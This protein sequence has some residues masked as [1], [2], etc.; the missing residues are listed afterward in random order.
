[1]AVPTMQYTE[2]AVLLQVQSLHSNPALATKASAWLSE[3]QNSS[4]A[5]P[6]ATALLQKAKEERNQ[7]LLV[8]NFAAHTIQA[9][10]QA[11]F[12]AATGNLEVVKQ[13][14][15]EFLCDFRLSHDLV[16]RPLAVALCAVVLFD[17]AWTD[18]VNS[19]IQTFATH[20]DYYRILAEVLS[21][22]PEELSNTNIAIKPQR[23]KEATHAV[24]SQTAVAFDALERLAT[25]STHKDIGVLRKKVVRATAAWIRAHKIAFEEDPP[26]TVTNGWVH[27]MVVHCA[28]TPVMEL[29]LQGLSSDDI[30]V[31]T[32]AA[33]GIETL[34]LL[35]V[36]EGGKPQSALCARIVTALSP[37]CHLILSD[38]SMNQEDDVYT[39]AMNV[40]GALAR[41]Q[42]PYLMHRV[43][44]AA[45]GASGGTDDAVYPAVLPPTGGLNGV[46]GIDHTQAAPQGA[47]DD[48]GL[49]NSDLQ[50]LQSPL[51]ALVDASLM[52]CSHP[53]LQVAEM[54]LDFWLNLATMFFP[55]AE[56]EY[57]RHQGD[58]RAALRLAAIDLWRRERKES[59]R[60]VFMTFLL[61]L[62]EIVSYKEDGACTED[63]EAFEAF[64]ALRNRITQN[65]AEITLIF[66]SKFA[67]DHTGSTLLGLI[68][69]VEREGVDA[70]HYSVPWN[71]LEANVYLLTTIATRAPRGED[72][73]I[74]VVLQRIPQIPEA[75]RSVQG[76]LL[77]SSVCRFITFTCTYAALQPEL[78]TGL[79]SYVAS[80]YMNFFLTEPL[81]EA[82][83]NH[84]QDTATDALSYLA[85]A[86]CGAVVGLG[87]D[88]V[89]RVLQDFNRLI[90]EPRISIDNRLMLVKAAGTV[91]S[92]LPTGELQS[93]HGQLVKP[94]ADN[95]Q[96][97]LQQ[98]GSDGMQT[99]AL[100]LFFCGLSA[101]RWTPSQQEHDERQEALAMQSASGLCHP[102]LSLVDAHLPLIRGAMEAKAKDEMCVESATSSMNTIL[103]QYR[104]ETVPQA[105]V[106][107]GFLEA[108]GAC[109]RI[110][111]N[112]FLLG[113]VRT[114]VGLYGNTPEESVTGKGG[115]LTSLL[116]EVFESMRL[117]IVESRGG[118]MFCQPDMVGMSVDCINCAVAHAALACGLF[119]SEQYPRA[120]ATV[121]RLLVTCNHPKVQ[122]ALLLFLQRSFVWVDP[123]RNLH[124]VSRYGQ[125]GRGPPP[126]YGGYPPPAQAPPPPNPHWV[127]TVVKAGTCLHQILSRPLPHPG[128]LD[129]A[130]GDPAGSGPAASAAMIANGATGGDPNSTAL[131]ECLRVLVS[132]LVIYGADL[133]SSLPMISQALYC[134]M[135]S[136][137]VELRTPEEIQRYGGGDQ[138]L[139]SALQ[140]LLTSLVMLFKASR[141]ALYD[142]LKGVGEEFLKPDEK[143]ELFAKMVLE[144]PDNDERKFSENLK[145]AAVNA[146]MG[147]KQARFRMS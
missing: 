54:G 87:A 8:T 82:L 139:Q 5:W 140:D 142:A 27:D 123:G 105:T 132:V 51:Q 43:K 94:L 76:A 24:L 141:Q 116:W 9:Q 25:A 125:G 35:M 130:G 96:R 100:R 137:N 109:A 45:S 135:H 143:E 112:V 110:H 121:T 53:S 102:V 80:H 58:Q 49:T 72:A 21:I 91:V 74:P 136:P 75:Y 70:A 88:A 106:L 30:E 22:L 118:Y 79:F 86:G 77:R 122:A 52:V 32:S 83:K 99:D 131:S 65:I 98:I 7:N 6:I 19:L 4:Q 33:D 145:T 31:S 17:N 3:F 57:L 50:A 66:G 78:L 46:G 84:G 144:P 62:F 38:P 101:V 85:Q 20:E 36:N 10:V 63:P 89:G 34:T 41:L 107:Q 59:L 103:A 26:E 114:L 12:P 90:M 81:P 42:L 15:L 138:M 113:A 60:D 67:V 44:G 115:A 56:E 146:K 64:G 48:D 128:D 37:L 71:Q 134:L 11:G 18:A 92:E 108:L 28:G 1:M 14:L 97:S 16:I 120:L 73:I 147:W 39:R 13:K 47:D 23:R 93:L 69:R 133:P 129:S 127:G 55:D 119:E 124:V 104:G 2:E 117:K 40:G 68:E 111:N 95:L 61:K 29:C 126:G